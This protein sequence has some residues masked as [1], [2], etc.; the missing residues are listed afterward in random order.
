M[1][2]R[3]WES[4]RTKT[5]SPIPSRS[6]TTEAIDIARKA[7]VKCLVL[8]HFSQRYPRCPDGVISEEPGAP[9]AVV[10]FDGLRARLW[11]FPALGLTSALT[12]DALDDDAP[13]DDEDDA[14]VAHPSFEELV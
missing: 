7:Q 1:P 2:G 11:E 3:G 13:Q 9:R 14:N 12:K 8:T 5:C 6:T 10:A 4:W